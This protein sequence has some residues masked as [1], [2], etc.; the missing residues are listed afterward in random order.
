MRA[1]DN[2]AL[3]KLLTVDPSPTALSGGQHIFS[4]NGQTN[5]LGFVDHKNSVIPTQL[6]LCNEKRVTDKT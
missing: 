4:V 1:R 5:I 3:P 6:G 2:W